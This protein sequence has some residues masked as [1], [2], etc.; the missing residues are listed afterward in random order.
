MKIAEAELVPVSEGHVCAI[1]TRDGDAPPGSWTASR[2]KGHLW[3][4]GDPAGAVG[5]LADGEQREG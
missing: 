4:P 1:V 3:D 5:P 2:A